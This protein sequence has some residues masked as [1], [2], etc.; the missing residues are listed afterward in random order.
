MEKTKK[1]IEVDVLDKKTNDY[2]IVIFNDNVNSFGHVIGSLIEICNHTHIQAEQCA[3]I[4]H[5]NG[6]CSVKT[7]EYPDLEPQC[8]ALLTC[9]LSAEI[10]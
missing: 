9:G 4:I 10:Q 8:S 7:G 2:Q 1:D 6:K 5:N 3:H